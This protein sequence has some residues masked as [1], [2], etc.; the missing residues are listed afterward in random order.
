M[1]REPMTANFRIRPLP[2]TFAAL[3]LLA[4]L[5]LGALGH[6]WHHLVDHDCDSG[7]SGT[8][9][10]CVQCSSLH[11]ATESAAEAAE[12]AVAPE[13]L[14]LVHATHTVARSL[15]APAP[16]SARAPPVA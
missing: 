6:G 14:G 3:V 2:R 10:A 5:L 7:T 9:H 15:H 11:A 1:L 16:R 4:A 13:P 8:R 12:L